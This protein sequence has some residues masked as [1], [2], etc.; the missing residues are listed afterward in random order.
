MIA[1][2]RLKLDLKKMTAWSKREIKVNG[3]QLTALKLNKVSKQL[4]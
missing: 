2:A 3:A 1:T 4:T